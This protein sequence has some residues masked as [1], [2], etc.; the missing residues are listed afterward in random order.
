MAQ[1]TPFELVD[2]QLWTTD[3]LPPPENEVFASL[4]E[5]P[6]PPDVVAR[7]TWREDCPVGLGELAYAQ[8]SFYGFDGLFHTGEL[9]V[10]LDHV[11]LRM[12]ACGQLGVVVPPR[13]GR[14]DRHQPVP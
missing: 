1:P 6:P 4:V 13:R 11:D 2:R 9:I 14:G 10:H 7:S 3:T 12:P 5:T 8:V